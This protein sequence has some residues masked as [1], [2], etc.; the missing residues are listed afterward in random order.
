MD[1][2]EFFN[3]PEDASITDIK[4]A[5]RHLAM[6]YHPDKNPSPYATEDFQSNVS[7]L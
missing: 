7:E 5:Y 6:Q 1:A 3:L 2:Y 4:R